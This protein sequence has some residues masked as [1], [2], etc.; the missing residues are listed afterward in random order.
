MHK[1]K[2]RMNI[3]LSLPI[4]MNQEHESAPA[5]AP[6][7]ATLYATSPYNVASS[8]SQPQRIEKASYELLNDAIPMPNCMKPSDMAKQF[9]KMYSFLTSDRSPD[10]LVPKEP[11]SSEAF[12]S[13]DSSIIFL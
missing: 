7:I 6:A 4:G 2:L 9:M 12:T 1:I 3:S 5:A 8:V 13:L 10:Y 11:T